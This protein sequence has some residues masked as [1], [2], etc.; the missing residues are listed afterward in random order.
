MSIEVDR[1]TVI[2]GVAASAAAAVFP[3]RVAAATYYP[4]E[5]HRRVLEIAKEQVERHRASLWRTDIVAIADFALPSSLPR[6]HF[7]NLD[8]GE[9]RSFLVAH[10]RGSD[11]EHDGFLKTFS[12]D[13]GSLA[14]SR[15]A[16]V[17]YEW[18]KGKYGT[19]I[20]L[21]GLSPENSNVLDRAI[22]LHPAWYA[23]PAMLDKWGKLGRSDGCFAMSETDF[24][25][26]LW[27]LSG[28]R[29]IYA[30]RLGLG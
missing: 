20:R 23:D 8:R 4:T 16:Y 24:N 21:G 26:A 13:V 15:G 14:T 11:P 9:V 2:A 19:S 25:E 6:F 7:A 5:Q 10:G 17:T 27:H 12:N 22:V 1:R 3:P 28:G 30:D 29:L 18:Y